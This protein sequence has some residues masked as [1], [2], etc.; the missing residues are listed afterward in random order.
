MQTIETSKEAFEVIKP[1]IPSIKSRILM[2]VEAHAG[3]GVTREDLIKLTGIH[4]NSLSGRITELKAGGQIKVR[5][6]RENSRGNLEDVYTLGDGIPPL[7]K[8]KPQVA[9]GMS[10]ERLVEV[11]AR[12]T[13]PSVDS[14][15]QLFIWATQP[16]GTDFWNRVHEAVEAKKLGP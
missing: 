13:E 8:T 12:A 16:E 5:G 7:P 9:V 2:V 14:V 10:E 6:T 4:Q 11:L 3:I 1:T 15:S